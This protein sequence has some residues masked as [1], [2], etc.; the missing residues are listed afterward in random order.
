MSVK[1][2]QLRLKYTSFGLDVRHRGIVVTFK[3]RSFARTNVDS[4]FLTDFPGMP[5]TDLPG[6]TPS[7]RSFNRS[8]LVTVMTTLLFTSQRHS[9]CSMLSL[10]ARQYQLILQCLPSPSRSNG[11]I[12]SPNLR[13][14]EHHYKRKLSDVDSVSRV[15]DP[16]RFQQRDRLGV[17]T[18]NID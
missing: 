2:G 4:I 12:L 13:K 18:T 1:A 11:R 7:M 5:Y 15:Q 8:D 6:V 17:Y 14:L 16:S 9:I 10:G 3:L